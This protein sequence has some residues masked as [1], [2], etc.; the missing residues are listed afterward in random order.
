MVIRLSILGIGYLVVFGGAV[1][2]VLVS[3]AYRSVKH[4]LLYSKV[5][6][7]VQSAGT[8]CS[9]RALTDSM[10]SAIAT[11]PK[12]ANEQWLD[13]NESIG[14]VASLGH[15][16]MAS[17]RSEARVNRRQQATVRFVSPADGRERVSLVALTVDQSRTM[18]RSGATLP[19]YAHRKDPAIVDPYY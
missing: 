10:R 19:I 13:C 15:E 6:A 18:P 12:L 5:D 4:S 16:V 9:V 17:F 2:F 7:I 3:G 8:G 1:I 11:S 14:A